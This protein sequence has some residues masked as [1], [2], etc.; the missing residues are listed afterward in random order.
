MGNESR[1]LLELSALALA[2]ALAASALFY[3]RSL[4]LVILALAGTDAHAVML[5]ALHGCSQ[6]VALLGTT[7]HVLTVSTHVPLL[8]GRT[9]VLGSLLPWEQ[10]STNIQ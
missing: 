4:S 1:Q 3:C 8:Q 9:E 7:T 2:L 10:S 5:S 6:Q